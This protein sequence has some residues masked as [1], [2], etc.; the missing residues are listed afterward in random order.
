MDD[1]IDVFGDQYVHAQ[2]PIAMGLKIDFHLGHP[3]SKGVGIEFKMPASTA[4]TQRAIGQIQQY[5]AVYGDQL[6][7]V[8]LPDKLDK[9]K[10]T[11]FAEQVASQ[12]VRV[13]VK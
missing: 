4:D 5:K 2:L 1:M 9:A 11:F 3:Q 7:L 13:L 12:G 8:L 10:E 6:L